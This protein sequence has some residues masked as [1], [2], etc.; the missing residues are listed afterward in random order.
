MGSDT[1][2]GERPIGPTR[3]Q[4]MRKGYQP[5]R[6]PDVQ[7]IPADKLAPPSADSSIA[8]LPNGSRVDSGGGHAGSPR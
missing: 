5:E 6:P 1:G 2:A 7:D 4:E 8:N 3:D